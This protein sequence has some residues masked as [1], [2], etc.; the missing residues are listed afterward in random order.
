VL[1]LASE[2]VIAFERQGEGGSLVVLASFSDKTQR[3]D[4][5]PLPGS[6]RRD[7]IS[8]DIWDLDGEVE[9]EPYALLW[10]E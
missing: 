8:G 10:L 3:V 6:A 7:L 1:P 5:K 4:L 9:L 2:H